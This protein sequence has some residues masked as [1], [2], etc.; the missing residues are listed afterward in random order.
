MASADIIA[1]L[2]LNAQNFT[3]ELQR[4]LGVAER[5]FGQTGNVIGRNISE[6]IGGGLQ[7]AA[8]RVPV[9]GNS[10]SGLSGPALVASAGIGAIVGV[11]GRGVSEAEAL[12]GS[13]R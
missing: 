4:E 13:V 1:R 5:R 11:L 12:A 9:L 2:K 6:G 3:S 10:L 7:S 8:S